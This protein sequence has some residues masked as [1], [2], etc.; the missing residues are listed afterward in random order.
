[1]LHIIYKNT[2]IKIP[3]RIQQLAWYI[4]IIDKATDTFSYN[5]VRWEFNKDFPMK[6]ITYPINDLSNHLFEINQKIVTSL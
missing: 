2:G 6:K 1:M 4:I 3:I 5:K